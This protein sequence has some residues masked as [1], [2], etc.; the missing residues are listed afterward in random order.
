MLL[1][2]DCIQLMKEHV[3][4]NSIELILTDLPYAITG[5]AWD[6]IIPFDL[7]WE[8]FER[9]TYDE[10]PIVLTAS[11][12]FTSALV[13]SNPKWFRYGWI[14]QKDNCSNFQLA[15]YQPLKFHED[16][17]VFSKKPHKYTPQNLVYTEL[18]KPNSE[19]KA[20]NLQHLA[21][22]KHR[23][24]YIQ[25]QTHYP[26]SIIK[27]KRNVGL[28]PTQKPVDLFE[29][30]IRTYTEK[31]ETV[32][33]CTAGSMTTAIAAHNTGRKYICIEKD[34]K[35]F[36][37]GKRRVDEHLKYEEKSTGWFGYE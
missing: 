6:E 5:C 18:V 10:S 23:N 26:K 36:E 8:Q 24:E 7:L 25:T 14:W 27:F 35:I 11:Q 20:G 9:I 13:M 4:D 19:R 32:L 22:H 1:H 33:D 28:H 29:Y 17:L 2:G 16:V 3:A 30:L 31:D 12:P 34:D 21:S 15:K 37:D